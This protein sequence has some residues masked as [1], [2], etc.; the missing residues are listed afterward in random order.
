MKKSLLIAV[1]ATV[2]LASTSVSANIGNMLSDVS[3]SASTGINLSNLSEVDNSQNKMGFSVRGNATVKAT[4]S[5]SI[6]TGIGFA[7]RGSAIKDGTY[8][9]VKYEDY[10]STLTYI[11]VPV[12]AQFNLPQDV[13]GFNVTLQG[14]GYGSYLLSAKKAGKV[15]GVEQ[16]STSTDGLSSGDYGLTFG[17]QLTRDLPSLAGKSLIVSAGYDLG[18]KEIAGKSKNKN[19][20]LGIGLQ[21]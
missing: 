1:A 14:G 16:D 7:Q 17:A 15:G 8:N 19:I 5:V 10:T 6:Q 21:F 11:D 20:Q 12:I 13:A 2:T 9:T 3:Y 18:L 4:E